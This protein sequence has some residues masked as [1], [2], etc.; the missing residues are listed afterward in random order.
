MLRWAITFLILALV[1]RVLGLGAIASAAA[2]IAQILFLMFLLMF[3]AS[4][5]V[6]FAR[7]KKV[8][9]TL[10]MESYGRR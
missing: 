5:V 2:G 1:T 9:E 6:K 8:E 3:T 10:I 7:R 4:L